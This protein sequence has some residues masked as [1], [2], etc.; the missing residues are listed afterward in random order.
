MTWCQG[1]AQCKQLIQQEARK[2]F[3]DCR[4]LSLEETCNLE[5]QQ[6]KLQNEEYSLYNTQYGITV[7]V[8]HPVGVY[9]EAVSVKQS[10]EMMDPLCQL[11]LA[12]LPLDFGE[13]PDLFLSANSS[14]RGIICLYIRRYAISH[15]TMHGLAD[16]IIT[17]QS[18]A[19]VYEDRN[20]LSFIW[21]DLED[22]N[23]LLLQSEEAIVR[24]GAYAGFS[25]PYKLTV[26]ARGLMV[27]ARLAAEQM[28]VPG[29]IFYSLVR[30]DLLWRQADRVLELT[31]HSP[32]EFCHNAIMEMALSDRD[33]GTEYI[34]SL[35]TYLR[36]GRR[37]REAS[38]QLNVHRNT[39]DYR[40]RRISELFGVNMENASICFELLFSIHLLERYGERALTTH[41]GAIGENKIA[42]VRLLLWDSLEGRTIAPDTQGGCSLLVINTSGQTEEILRQVLQKTRTAFPDGVFAFNDDAVYLA[43]LNEPDTDSISK[44]RELLN[45]I[46]LNGMLTPIFPLREIAKRIR[47]LQLYQ[48]VIHNIAAK[49]GLVL[50]QEYLSDLFFLLLQSRTNLSAYYCDQ[51]IQVMDLDY[52]NNSDLSGSLYAF[53]TH[54]M[55][56]KDAA[57]AA[58]IHRN[59]LEYQLKKIMP[60]IGGM[61]GER[62]RFEMIC[63]YRMLLAS[64]SGQEI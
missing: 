51:V 48:Q 3:K 8:F 52:E 12:E 43:L 41:A 13:Y 26:S 10:I 47:L 16:A 5:K 24:F 32:A 9:I 33:S 39:L 55:D 1:I 20:G 31:G 46:N 64:N 40:I 15:A 42:N 22:L 21:S 29:V 4:F 14:L 45:E 38:L 54:F 19:L 11:I 18:P 44:A 25:G 59:T 28:D 56:M 50:I 57:G 49:D 60:L 7:V 27:K 30:W 2:V 61:P 63:T 36:S 17:I 23:H 34:Q 53:L 58:R 37:L 62:L 6:P 35:S